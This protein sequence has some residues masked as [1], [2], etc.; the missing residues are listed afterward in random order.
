MM[1]GIRGGGAERFTGMH[2]TGKDRF[3]KTENLSM[4][5]SLKKKQAL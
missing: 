3:F 4:E 1:H 2:G 5:S